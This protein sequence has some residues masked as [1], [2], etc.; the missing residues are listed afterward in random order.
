MTYAMILQ[1]KQSDMGKPPLFVG[2]TILP[3]FPRIA[4]KLLGRLRIVSK[5]GIIA[6]GSSPGRG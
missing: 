2:K 5:T 1:N 3:H 6:V 4:R